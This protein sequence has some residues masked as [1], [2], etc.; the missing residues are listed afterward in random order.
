MVVEVKCAHV[1]SPRGRIDWLI[2]V[3]PPIGWEVCKGPG[4]VIVLKLEARA[5]EGRKRRDEV[6]VVVYVLVMDMGK[7]W[8]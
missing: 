2:S 1:P 7:V 5:V 6:M 8:G 3:Q 4:V